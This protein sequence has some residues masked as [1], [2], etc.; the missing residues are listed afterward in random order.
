MEAAG[1]IGVREMREFLS[2]DNISELWEGINANP[3]IWLQGFV[4]TGYLIHLYAL[5]CDF[6]GDP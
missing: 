2:T 5:G 6:K 1:G 3:P 4:S